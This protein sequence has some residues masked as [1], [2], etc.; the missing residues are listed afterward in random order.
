[1]IDTA[2]VPR[3][4]EIPVEHTWDLTKV[5]PDDAAWE[6]AVTCLLETLPRVTELQGTIHQGPQAL[7]RVLQTRDETGLP[8][9]QI[10]VYAHMRRDSDSADPAG[11][12]L[13]EKAGSIAARV[14]AALAFIE[15]EILTLSDETIRGR[16]EEEPGLAQYDFALSEILRMRR[17][18]R[19][20]E[21]E[22]VLA[23]Y[24]DVTRTPS[25]IF[26]MLNNADMTFPPI[27][28]EEGKAVG[29]SHARYRRFMESTNRRVRHDTFFGYYESY[30]GVRNTLG[31]TLAGAVRTHVVNARVR[32]Y[33]SA[34]E[35]ALEPNKIP[36]DVYHN[37]VA[38][39][40]ANLPR[41]HRYIALRKRM[42]GLEDLHV[43]DL[44]AP[45]VPEAD[46]PVPFSEARQTI[47][48]ALAPMG[49]EYQAALQEAFGSRWI[50][51][52][53]NVGKRSGAYSGG[54]YA[55]PPYILLNYQDR[56]DDMFT[57]AHELGHSMH[58]FFTRR[59]Q[60][61]VCSD[62]TIFVA[63]VASTLN[64]ALLT[65]HLLKTRDDIALRKHLIVQQLE[66]MRT[67][68]FRQTM[69]ADFEHR[70]HAAVEAGE[71]LT[72]EWMSQEYY[73]LVSRYHGPD[74]VLDEP[75]AL[76]WARI[77]HFFY[78]FYVYQ[79]ATGLSAALALSRQILGEGAPAVSRYLAF[80]RSGSSRP[81][82]EL[83]RLAGVDM[84]S[85]APIQQAMDLMEDLL[86][87]LE[88]LP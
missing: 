41:L 81:P 84:T 53:E 11:Q 18:V 82:I 12:A 52:Y 26:G 23:Q 79:Y 28:D 2:Q 87:Q 6:Q 76:E 63:E 54:A 72:T 37:L 80:L 1:M 46:R 9:D 75:I 39:I 43:Y 24:G 62:Y 47:L 19:S 49:S 36:V 8:L 13:T 88:A 56:L 27:E 68:I 59:T 14:Q 40:E 67:V 71:A 16:V 30:H 55:T 35:A 31:T 29:L 61:F 78:N 48:D 86:D 65:D 22:G 10:R 38:T 34:L 3:R 17:H 5:Y 45:L 33:R 21:V 25:E 50:D 57:L 73:D 7:L 58:S 70:I 15:P 4:S 51:I 32:N 20:A 77:P 85:P 69:F 74:V 44:Y 60:P 42:M 64:E 66:D 83:L